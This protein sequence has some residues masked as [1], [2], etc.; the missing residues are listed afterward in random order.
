[1][2]IETPFFSIILIVPDSYHLVSVTLDSI[3]EQTFQDFE[4]ILIEHGLTERDLELLSTTSDKISKI[5]P[6]YVRAHSRLMNKGLGF[7]R[8]KYV[9]F[10]LPGDILLGKNALLDLKKQMEEN[11]FP[12]IVATSYLAR[13]EDKSTEAVCL[14]LSLESL[15]KGQMATRLQSIFFLKNTLEEVHGFDKRYQYRED[16]ELLC[17]LLKSRK[18][19]VLFLRRIFVDYVF[20]RKRTKE[21]LGV[22][23]ETMRILYRHFGLLKVILWFFFQ[24]HFHLLEWW[25][26]SLKMAF[27]R[28]A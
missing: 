14:P 18:R 10:L 3:K 5:H 26:K 7:A 17:R 8:G 13:D 28:R 2:K 21:F 12:P 25:F 20:R 1:M 23:W 11:Q 22:E 19:K 24:D 6:S 9:Q 16:F 15:K 4:I 27:L